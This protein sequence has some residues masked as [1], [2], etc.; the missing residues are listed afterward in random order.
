M[1]LSRIKR[2]IIVLFS[3]LTLI[4]FLWILTWQI[5]LF[6]LKDITEDRLTQLFQTPV[7]L[8]V[9]QILEWK[10]WNQLKI[11]VENLRLKGSPTD[12]ITQVAYANRVSAVVP[13][14]D[15][16][17]KKDTIHVH[18]FKVDSL[19]LD[20]Y[21]DNDRK[22]NYKLF[23]P[24]EP[25]RKKGPSWVQFHNSYI[26]ACK[27]SYYFK[28]HQRDYQ[29]EL[30]NIYPQLTIRKEDLDIQ[31]DLEGYSRYL[32][33]K[34][35]QFMQNAKLKLRYDA[36]IKKY[37]QDNIFRECK[38]EIGGVP[39][40]VGGRFYL[41]W[42]R[43]YDLKLNVLNANTD[44]LLNLFPKEIQEKV[45]V[46]DIDGNV[47]ITG[48]IIGKWKPE[49]HLHFGTDS[50]N[51]TN[52]ITKVGL[53]HLNIKGKFFNG[54]E[55][56]K[57]FAELKVDTLSGFIYQKPFLANFVIKD[58]N[59]FFLNGHFEMSQ[60]L[61][62]V[63]KWMGFDDN[64]N[65]KG[66]I[67]AN[68]DI[69]GNLKDIAAFDMEKVHL[70]GYLNADDIS[71][72]ASWTPFEISN[73]NFQLLFNNHEIF[74]KNAKSYINQQPVEMKGWLST[75]AF[76]L[77]P[78][79]IA[80]ASITFDTLS[81]EKFIQKSI[82][83]NAKIFPSIPNNFFVDLD[84][85]AKH[86]LYKKVEVQ[87]TYANLSLKPNEFFIHRLNIK[88]K[89][90]S[91]LLN[92]HFHQ[93]HKDTIKFSV[94]QNINTRSIMDIVSELG[95]QLGKWSDLDISLNNKTQWNGKVFKN[96]QN[97]LDGNFDVKLW[98]EELKYPK[99]VIELSNF[100]ASL[101]TTLS[102]I[103]NPKESS[104]LIH[105]IQGAVNHQP[106]VGSIGFVP[107][108]NGFMVYPSLEMDLC[109]DALQTFVKPDNISDYEGNFNFTFFG[110]G[111]LKSY[112]KP[113]SA[114]YQSSHGKIQIN[115][116]SFLIENKNLPV[117][118]ILGK[119]EYNDYGV[120]A[121]PICGKMGNSDFCFT[122]NTQNI[123][124]YLFLK[125]TRLDGKM[126]LISDSL[127][128]KDFTAESFSKKE[129]KIKNFNIKLPNN[130]NLDIDAQ[131]MN[132]IF[133]KLKF[134]YVL[135]NACVHDKMAFIDDFDAY[136]DKGY[137]KSHLIW[138]GRDT[139][140]QYVSANLTLHN[141]NV[142]N[143]MYDFNNFK[144]SFIEYQ[145][146]EGDLSLDGYFELSFPS[147]LKTDFST[148]QGNLS[149]V[150]ENGVLRNFIPFQKLKGIVKK[151]YLE[152]SNFTMTAQNIIVQNRMLFIPK[153]EI[154]SDIA[155]IV[156]SGT[157]TFDQ[158]ID[159]RIQILRNKRRFLKKQ[160]KAQA[161]HYD[162]TVLLFHFKGSKGKYKLTYDFNSLWNRFFKKKNK[163]TS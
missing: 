45:K 128:I 57:P 16:F 17:M 55:K 13:I 2:L 56:G 134:Q 118:S 33:E 69:E 36:N 129:E 102:K 81:P 87:E 53:H 137:W 27:F 70:N 141:L 96:S 100:Q 19:F 46:Y 160:T 150:L 7:S 163:P 61:A 155:N 138:D 101:S 12:S 88:G 135:L 148:L 162:K 18:N 153:L 9:V 35:T 68:I 23:K 147:D 62:T 92:A 43:D 127:F 67:D 50:L 146:V 64:K 103:T 41:G 58:F 89:E 34:N 98:I 108:K 122:G 113:D 144:Q 30:Q 140:N 28:L 5:V 39:I 145:N 85:Q 95:F 136:F 159:Y 26:R 120:W 40:E 154:R 114:V 112:I 6:Y 121:N 106:F 59:R 10:S 20:F 76:E 161:I 131:I 86:I 82:Q 80:N 60:N 104:W 132:A 52:T 133:D 38:L 48:K 8:Q 152:S 91:L 49:F 116:L 142:K 75:K 83:K 4:V 3:F 149:F 44:S 32:R 37:K 130:V 65:A 22:K 42:E 117:D 54:G 124:A 125:N 156:I 157:H 107:T 77:K 66:N 79:F 21:V 25:N 110:Q 11:Q 90:D 111:L 139:S 143:F 151:K 73:T 126:S 31:L 15:I 78:Q 72:P 123:L 24:Y 109:L 63:G 97:E 14:I 158:D 99:P 94:N 29:F 84:I 51:I 93:F 115:D 47:N 74:L 105:H 119:V 71:L 1:K